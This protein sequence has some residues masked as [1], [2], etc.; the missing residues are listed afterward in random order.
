[1]IWILPSVAIAIHDR[2]LAEHGGREG[3]RDAALLD[4]ALARPRK[5]HAYVGSK[6][7]VADLAASVATGLV[8]N[9]PFV[10]GNKRTAHVCYR[11]FLVRNC[12][13]FEA[14]DVEKLLQMVG[15]A[16]GTVSEKEFA[17]WLRRHIR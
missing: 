8:R 2:Q 11:A 1:M 9:M 6:A 15:L 3:I 12:V 7:D 5:L 10:D 16:A 13:A 17:D 14:S 4:S